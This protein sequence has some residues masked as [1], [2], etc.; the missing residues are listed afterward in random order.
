MSE[1]QDKGQETPINR[2]EL[3]M[4]LRRESKEETEDVETTSE[5]TQ[6]AGNMT[7]ALIVVLTASIVV[8][9]T[10]LGF[11]LGWFASAYYQSYMEHVVEGSE[12]EELSQLQIT[13]HPEMLDSEGNM[14]PFTVSKLISV[15]FDPVDAFDSDPFPDD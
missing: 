12:N 14:I 7:T 9:G 8:G 5:E 6:E 4:R 2:G 1:E 10:I 15:E 11:I 3:F 13:P